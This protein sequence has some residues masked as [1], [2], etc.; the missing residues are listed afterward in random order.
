MELDKLIYSPENNNLSLDHRTIDA[1][2]KLGA[3]PNTLEHSGDWVTVSWS[4][5]SSPSVEDWIGV[6]TPPTNGNS[7]DPKHHAPVKFQVRP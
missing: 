5:V 7:I 6:Y 3:S 1:N 4:G 2:I